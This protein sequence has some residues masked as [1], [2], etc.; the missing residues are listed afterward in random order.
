MNF[1]DRHSIPSIY[2][3][4]NVSKKKNTPLKSISTKTKESLSG[5]TKEIMKSTSFKNKSRKR[6]ESNN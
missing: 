1:V 5:Q 3:G 2:E 4:S 6:F